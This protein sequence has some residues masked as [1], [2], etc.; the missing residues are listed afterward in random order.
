MYQFFI[1]VEDSKVIEYLKFLTFL[2]R[3]EIEELDKKNQEAPHLREA[4]NAL[5]REVITF[6]HG[7]DAYNEA[8]KISKALFSGDI[9]SL[10]AKEIEMG[11][12]DLPSIELEGELNIVDALIK[13]GL[14]QSKR[15]AREFVSN[16]AVSINGDK[17]QDLT[18]N[19]SKDKAIENKFIVLRRGKK[20]YALIRF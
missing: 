3:E 18:F 17:C 12:N 7:E 19:L 4:H 2:S 9:K 11:F 14:A 1:N 6:I 15:E 16:G 5:A 20:L 13:A 8:L 10:N